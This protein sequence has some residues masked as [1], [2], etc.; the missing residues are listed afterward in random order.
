MSGENKTIILVHCRPNDAGAVV[1][2]VKDSQKIAIL[3]MYREANERLSRGEEIG[4][5]TDL[6]LKLT[7]E[8]VE[9]VIN[10]GFRYEKDNTGSD[11]EIGKLV[12]QH[13][14]PGGVMQSDN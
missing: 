9:K 2:R 5:I 10:P 11:G 6:S 3:E 13:L 7:S 14:M 1:Y 4:E 8:E 12:L